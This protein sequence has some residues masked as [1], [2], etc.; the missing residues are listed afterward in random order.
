M[1][2]RRVSYSAAA[3][4]QIILSVRNLSGPEVLQKLEKMLAKLAAQVE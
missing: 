3:G 2:K 4:F 1:F